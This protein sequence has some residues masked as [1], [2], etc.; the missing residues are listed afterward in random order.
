MN[1]SNLKNDHLW[2]FKD[3][4][5]EINQDNENIYLKGDRYLICGYEMP[6][7]IPF[8][9]NVFG[10]NF[11]V[12]NLQKQKKYII[13]P[14]I[15]NEEFINEIRNIKNSTDDNE[16]LIH[17]H[18]QTS[19]SE[20]QHIFY[21][22]ENLKRE[23]D[24][25]LFPKN[26]DE[27]IKIIDSAK[28][29]NVCLIPYGGGSSVSCALQCP[30]NEERMIVS[31]DM[32]LL[33]NLISLDKENNLAVFGAG[34]TGLEM[35]KILSKNGYT[36][37]HEPDSMEFS[38]LGG[39]ISTNASGM[40]RSKYGNIEDIVVNYKL[41]SPNGLL[42]KSIN[43]PRNS[44]GSVVHDCIFGSEGNF[45]IIT[46]ATIKIHK[47]PEL[48]EYQSIIFPNF[49]IG[50]K[51]MKDLTINNKYLLPASIR[52]VDNKQLQFAM[53]LKPEKTY[54]GSWK[55]Y[56]KDFF[57]EKYYGFD[58]NEMVLCT[59]TFEG[60]INE[61]YDKI[62]G[63]QSLCNKCGG[64]MGGSENG[65]KGY[66]L[67]FAIA[68]IRDFMAKFYCMG[69]TFETTVPWN[70][71][72][73][74]CKAVEYKLEQETKSLNSKPFLS[75]RI[76]QSYETGVCIYFMLALYY[77]DIENIVEKFEDLEEKLREAIL[78]NGGSISHHHG[79]GKHRSKFIIRDSSLIEKNC[80]K[81]IK[82]SLDPN[83]VFGVQNGIFDN[84]LKKK[85]L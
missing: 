7:F 74:V 45:G 82:N 64:L 26:T 5:F 10:V 68:Y 75:Y 16:R 27:I 52:L 34:I 36:S 49:N 22:K 3:T 31:V 42:E 66:Q 39:W 25:V 38:T 56:I 17:S 83:N 44:Y 63:I 76:T 43:T 54:F 47:K 19:A 29:F 67:T 79:I 37:G 8:V 81:S 32:K 46:E 65:K 60:K 4:S 69:E 48:K 73:D 70:N 59:L 1:S 28:M 24:L 12:K 58:K 14:P 23:V 71:I 35:E 53:A 77:K 6:N 11:D 30:E 55:E 61:V 15:K 84:N 78:D 85:N 72:N 40:K 13:K 18:G 57:L 41:Y 2:G 80:I 20:I 62:S 21:S 50:I 51:F 33:S 9:R